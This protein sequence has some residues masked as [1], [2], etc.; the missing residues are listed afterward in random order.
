MVESQ[1]PREVGV[2]TDRRI[3]CYKEIKPRIEEGPPSNEEVISYSAQSTFTGIL[4]GGCPRR[5]SK[6]TQL[7]REVW[8]W[9]RE[10]GCRRRM[11]WLCQQGTRQ[12]KAI[13]V[14]PN[15]YLNLC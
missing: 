7:L 5:D 14:T 2:S 10:I 11:R 1:R 6:G 13:W 8:L 9:Q 12:G 3:S 4:A 15:D